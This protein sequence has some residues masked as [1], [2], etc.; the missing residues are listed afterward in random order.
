MKVESLGNDRHSRIF[1]ILLRSMQHNRSKIDFK[2][3]HLKKFPSACLPL[4]EM[5]HPWLKA[6]EEIINRSESEL[7]NF[8]HKLCCFR[9]IKLRFTSIF[10]MQR[11]YILQKIFPLFWIPNFKYKGHCL[12][13]W[14]WRNLGFFLLDEG[15]CLDVIQYRFYTMLGLPPFPLSSLKT[16][17]LF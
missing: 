12:Q 17:N 8:F 2:T 13:A 3:S 14:E 15:F 16:A 11:Y 5:N 7:L 1:H 9:V 6:A 4:L 10:I